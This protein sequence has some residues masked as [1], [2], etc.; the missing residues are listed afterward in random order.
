MTRRRRC[1][2]ARNGVGVAGL[3]VSEVVN[4]VPTARFDLVLNAVE[5]DDELRLS[6]AVYRVIRMTMTLLYELRWGGDWFDS[7]RA[8]IEADLNALSRI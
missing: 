5:L 8:T 4:H 3:R 7:Y 2:A 6:F 1:G